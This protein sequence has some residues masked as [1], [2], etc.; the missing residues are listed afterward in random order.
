MTHHPVLAGP[1]ELELHSPPTFWRCEPAWSWVSPPQQDHLL[2]CV[3]DGIGRLELNGSTRE[4]GPGV[5]A[6]FAPG[7]APT[8][9]H[10]PR[11]RLLVFGMHFAVSPEGVVPG[12]RWAEVQDRVLLGALARSSDT[13]YRRGDALGRRQAELCLE[14]LLGL[15]WDAAH[16]PQPSAT[17]TAIQEVAQAIRQDPSRDWSVTEMAAQAVLSRAQFTRRFVAQHGT[18]PAQYVIQARVERAHQLL[19]ETGMTV[20][21]VAAA[22]G[23]TDIAYFSRQYKYRTGISPGQVRK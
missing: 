16:S 18:S 23:Y 8:A 11:R 2:W 4:L 17:D 12:E 14:Q 15:I 6:V 5:C 21:Q 7:D 22:L 20:T 3:L 19:T 10:D 1:V 9:S 13:A